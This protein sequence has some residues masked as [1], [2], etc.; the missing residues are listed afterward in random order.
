MLPHE[1]GA[2]M[3][4]HLIAVSMI[5]FSFTGC[6]DETEQT[7][8]DVAGQ[9]SQGEEGKTESGP[10]EPS[11]TIDLG[12]A[13]CDAVVFTPDG[14]RLV[15]FTARDGEKIQAFEVDSGKKLAEFPVTKANGD[16]I[17]Y[18]PMMSVSPNG[19]LLSILTGSG[20]AEICIF[21]LS[22]G[23]R[24]AAIAETEFGHPTTGNVLFGADSKTVIFASYHPEK[25][26]RKIVRYELSTGTAELVYD[27]TKKF[28][29][30]RMA[31]LSDSKSVAIAGIVGTDKVLTQL[32]ILDL[33]SGSVRKID[34]GRGA[35]QAV[36]VAHRQPVL[37]FC[38]QDFE[39][40]DLLLLQVDL[41]AGSVTKGR[42]VYHNR[43]AIL[44]G[45]QVVTARRAVYSSTPA[46]VDG[47]TEIEL[48]TGG[49]GARVIA[50]SPV[51]HRVAAPV[52]KTIRI[53]DVSRWAN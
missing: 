32:R 34:L 52:K 47:E 37:H 28:T 6:G 38:F 4:I 5:L 45:G 17:D 19:E 42:K 14:K 51:S 44:A 46:I 16:K 35:P 29:T 31:M 27:T 50:S 21:E 48:S 8:D 20:R 10:V 30:Q 25:V 24:N 7:A 2:E 13:E 41:D 3:R 43:Y 36:H 53:F 15:A 22:T 9:S 49:S 1:K 23:S 40:K 18:P 26:E 33:E 39:E 12:K 11:I